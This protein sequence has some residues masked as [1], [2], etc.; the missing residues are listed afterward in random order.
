MKCGNGK[1][2]RRLV[3]MIVQDHTVKKEGNILQ[4]SCIGTAFI[5]ML[6]KEGSG[7]DRSDGKTSK[8]R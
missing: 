7:K 5:S 8:K 3:R 2:W 4:T 1:G 6:L